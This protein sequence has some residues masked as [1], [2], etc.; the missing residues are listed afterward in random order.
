LSF[1][2]ELAHA[3]FRPG[4]PVLLLDFR[5]KQ[6]PDYRVERRFSLPGKRPCLLQQLFLYGQCY[7][8]HDRLHMITQS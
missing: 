5:R 7:I 4:D 1:F 6:T 2:D 3:F 8:L